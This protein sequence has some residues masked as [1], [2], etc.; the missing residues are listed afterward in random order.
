MNFVNVDQLSPRQR[1]AYDSP[2]KRLLV[3]GGPGSGKTAVALLKARRLLEDEPPTSARR[4]L[5]LSLTRAA[6][7]EVANRVPRV[8][9]GSLGGRIEMATFHS[10]ALSVLDGFRRYNGQGSEPVVLVSEAEDKLGLAPTGGLKFDDLLAATHRL[11]DAVPWIEELHAHRYLAVM[12]DE[13][14]DSTDEQVHLLERL[15]S[16][17]TLICLA[18]PYQEIYTAFV[19]GTRRDRIQRLANS[20]GVEIVD[21]KSASF[22]DPSLVIPRAAEAIRNRSFNAPE[23]ELALAQG[24]LRVRQASND[25]SYLD[26]LEDAIRELGPSQ[27]RTVGVFLRANVSV[28]EFAGHLRDAGIEHEIVGLDAASGEA[29]LAA[30]AIAQHAI[31]T[32]EWTSALRALGLFDAASIR[33]NPE[34]RARNLVHDPRLLPLGLQNRLD[35]AK[36]QFAEMAGLPLLEFLTAV[37]AF[38][39]EQFTPRGRKLWERGIDDLIGQT[40][41]TAFAPLNEQTVEL[42][43]RVARDRRRFSSIDT[44]VGALSPVRL[45]TTY[46]CKGR[47]MDAVVI[48]QMPNERPPDADRW[49]V[50]TRVHFVNLTRA[51][52]VAVVLIPPQP[53]DFYEPYLSLLN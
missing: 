10:F 7:A 27:T 41:A 49:D 42:V 6:T 22:R 9:A 48:A 17:A 2:A 33:G 1:A 34:S 25:V 39:G 12:C 47:E 44:F 26:A 45:M 28:T 29:Q 32:G 20:G 14:Q 46:Q 4:V 43:T 8:L 35:V 19:P 37:Q 30:A 38:W 40:L 53:N 11:F 36:D 31:G 18:D 16:K 13:F 51:R 3:K 5:F 21:L 24:R 52:D 50:A 23:V 15:A